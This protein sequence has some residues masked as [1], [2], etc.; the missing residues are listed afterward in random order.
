MLFYWN[1]SED[2]MEGEQMDGQ[3]AARSGDS[4]GPLYRVL[5]GMPRTDSSRTRSSS[6]SSRHRDSHQREAVQ[7]HRGRGDAADHLNDIVGDQTLQPFTHRVARQFDPSAEFRVPRAPV[8]DEKP[9]PVKFALLDHLQEIRTVLPDSA[10]R[11]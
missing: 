2:L 5:P 1:D 6:R 7:A 4:G 9:K 11:A 10:G 3:E 8:C